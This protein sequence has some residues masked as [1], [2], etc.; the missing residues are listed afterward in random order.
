MSRKIITFRINI[1]ILKIIIICL[2]KIGSYRRET[3]AAK[4]THAIINA[5]PINRTTATTMRSSMMQS[6]FGHLTHV[7]SRKADNG[8]TQE[9]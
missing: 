8:F 2:L 1:S 4:V 6:I 7:A 3:V 5:L 9:P